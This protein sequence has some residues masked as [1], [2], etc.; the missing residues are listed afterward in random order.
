ME[1]EGVVS[2]RIGNGWNRSIFSE[3]L[4]SSKKFLTT[5]QSP[6]IGVGNRTYGTIGN[7]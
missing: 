1:K 3:L 5:F 4:K 6:L 7:Q 2:I